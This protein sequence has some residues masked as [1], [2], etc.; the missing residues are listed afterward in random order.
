MSDGFLLKNCCGCTLP[1]WLRS[2]SAKPSIGV[3]GPSTRIFQELIP[4]EE[5]VDFTDHNEGQAN[6]KIE[7]ASE[8]YHQV[9]IRNFDE[10]GFCL[11]APGN[12]IQCTHALKLSNIYT[13]H[14]RTIMM[15]K[16]D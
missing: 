8:A 13:R 7:E 4:L 14:N 12:G 3:T 1:V 15:D 5:M 2:F 10:K 16:S 11:A 6:H 9:D